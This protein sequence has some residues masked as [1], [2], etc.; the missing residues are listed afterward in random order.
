[1]SITLSVSSLFHITTIRNSS[2]VNYFREEWDQK[3]QLPEVNR[4]STDINHGKYFTL[5]PS[6]AYYSPW[7]GDQ[8]YLIYYCT[9]PLRLLDFREY[10]RTLQPGEQLKY[11]GF[12][13]QG[14]VLE[15]CLF[16]PYEVL[17]HF[18]N[19]K[20]VPVNCDY[21]RI[22]KE[23][24]ELLDNKGIIKSQ[25]N[26]ETVGIYSKCEPKDHKDY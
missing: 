6:D 1:M 17:S 19:L 13:E 12:I 26:L 5:V 22:R 4:H 20:Y 10:R 8:A 2:T 18:H 11:D 23:E 3:Y 15:I 14:D 24:K 25:K 9:R 16:R 21:D 7:I